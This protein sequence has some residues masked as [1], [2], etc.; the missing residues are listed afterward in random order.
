M[1]NEAMKENWAAGGERWA[2]NE[3]IIDWVFAPV[4][5]AIIE[6]ADLAGATRVLDV[7]CGTGALLGA[8]VAAGVAAVGVDISPSMVEAAVRRV[9]EA[10]VV[11]ADAQTDDLLAAGPGV[12]FDRV[13]SRFG[14]M[15]FDDPVAAFAN[16]RSAA[17]GPRRSTCSC[18]VSVHSPLG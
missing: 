15:F 12:A 3:R 8:T 16:I 4:T 13:L 1:A 11:V 10:T 7:G 18:P 17:G 6:A 14:V 9:P 2:A 5:E